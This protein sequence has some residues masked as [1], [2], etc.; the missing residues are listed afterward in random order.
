MTDTDVPRP[1]WG[2]IDRSALTSRMPVRLTTPTAAEMA[3]PL[4]GFRLDLVDQDLSLDSILGSAFQQ[5]IS[6][7]AAKVGDL[8]ATLQ[9]A[10]A[11]LGEPRGISVWH[12]TFVEGDRIMC[13]A[14]YGFS[15]DVPAGE[16]QYKATGV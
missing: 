8:I 16:V 6:R 11:D 10:T 12:E 2:V 4:P 3:R 9:A 15:D 14:R 7:E 5:M 13:R 1:G